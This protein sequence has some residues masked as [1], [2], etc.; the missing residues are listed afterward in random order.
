MFIDV[1]G[2]QVMSPGGDSFVLLPLCASLKALGRNH[3]VNGLYFRVLYDM[4]RRE[5]IRT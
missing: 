5:V 4:A 2:Q 3:P 1:M